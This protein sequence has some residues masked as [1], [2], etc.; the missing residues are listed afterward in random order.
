[1]NKIKKTIY[2]FSGLGLL[3]GLIFSIFYYTHVPKSINELITYKLDKTWTYTD[4]YHWNNDENEKV[5]IEKAYS[6]DK[7]GY[8]TFNIF[9][10]KGY[11]CFNL[12]TK[13]DEQEYIEILDDIHIENINNHKYYIGTQESDDME[14]MVLVAFVEDGDYIFNI[15]LTN[16]DEQ[17]TDIQKEKFNEILNTIQFN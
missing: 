2:A 8:I 3:C 17:I 11:D 10:Y 1:M 15:R 5:I 14:N 4:S 7:Y 13:I 16:F 6:S 12:F 9:S